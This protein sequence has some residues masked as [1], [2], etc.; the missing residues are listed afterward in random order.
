[1]T[2]SSSGGSRLF[3]SLPRIGTWTVFQGPSDGRKFSQMWG[4]SRVLQQWGL[5]MNKSAWQSSF[6]MVRNVRSHFAASCWDLSPL[7]V[8]QQLLRKMEDEKVSMAIWLNANVDYLHERRS[9]VTVTTMTFRIHDNSNFKVNDSIYNIRQWQMIIMSMPTIN[10]KMTMILTLRHLKSQNC[11]S[12][13]PSNSCFA[14][15]LHWHLVDWAGLELPPRLVFFLACLDTAVSFTLSQT[16]CW[17]CV[18]LCGSLDR[19]TSAT[20]AKRGFIDWTQDHCHAWCR[21]DGT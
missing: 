15:K 6:R 14:R 12:Q 10:N 4:C 13:C 1:M 19:P 8:R 20:A 11:S 7:H 18:V 17:S 21:L 2:T 16:A 3:G 5:K 9:T